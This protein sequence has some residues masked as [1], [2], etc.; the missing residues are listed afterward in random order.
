M[1]KDL[2]STTTTVTDPANENISPHP[3]I[4]TNDKELLNAAG[5]KR[6]YQDFYDIVLY[7]FFGAI[8]G[9]SAWLIFVF[10]DNL[11]TL[12]LQ[13]FCFILFGSISAIVGLF[14]LSLIDVDNKK[15]AIAIAL[16]CGIF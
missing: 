10:K 4:S 12:D 16:L 7:S 11:N 6:K 1:K 2:E 15:H 13:L 3:I 8:G 5:N 9:F 14:L